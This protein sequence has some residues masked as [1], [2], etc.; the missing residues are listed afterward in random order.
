LVLLT[1]LLILF[2]PYIKKLVAPYF[3]KKYNMSTISPSKQAAITAYRNL[4]KTQREVFTGK[5]KDK[6]CL[7]LIPTPPAI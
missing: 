3:S 7:S 5:E 4:L 2:S 1:L 6:Q